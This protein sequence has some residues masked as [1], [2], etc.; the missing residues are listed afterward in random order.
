MHRGPVRADH[1][2]SVLEH[3]QVMRKGARTEAVGAALHGLTAGRPRQ[4]CMG[5]DDLSEKKQT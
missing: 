1:H 5:M 4:P 3:G 2:I